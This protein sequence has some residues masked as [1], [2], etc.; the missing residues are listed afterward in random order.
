ME[1]MELNER[2][3]DLKERLENDLYVNRYDTFKQSV[4]FINKSL[5]FFNI[6]HKYT[7]DEF[8]IDFTNECLDF[9]EKNP[10]VDM[11]DPKQIVIFIPT[12]VMSMMINAEKKYGLK[13]SDED[14]KNN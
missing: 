11:Q 3:K 9:M 14:L 4:F 10:D 2:K 12:I 7:Y 5:D 1:L 6:N 8:C 13:S